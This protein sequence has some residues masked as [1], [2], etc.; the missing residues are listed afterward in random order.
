MIIIRIQHH[1]VPFLSHLYAADAAGTIQGGGAV[2]GKGG[3]GLLDTHLHIDAS[4][5]DSE[6]DGTGEAT[7]GIKVGGQCY[8]TAGVNHLTPAGIR[9]FQG[10]GGK[11]EQGG[12]H[13]FV[14]HGM[15]V[16]IGSV[17]QVVGGKFRSQSRTAQRHYFIGMELQRQSHITSGSQQ[18]SG[19]PDGEHALLAK[20]I[21]K[22]CGVSQATVSYV[23]NNRQNQ[24]ISEET[25]RKVLDAVEALHYYPNASAK[26][27]RTKN[28][29][30][31]GIVCAK[32]YS[33]QAFLN[34]FTGIS[35]YLS[36]IDYTITIFNEMDDIDSSPD[37]VKSYYSNVIDGLIFISNDDHAAFTK[38]ADENHIPYVVICMDGVFSKKT[39]FPHA[40]E[41]ALQECASFCLEKGIREV[42]YF[43]IS[44]DGLLVN[45]KYPLFESLL[46]RTAPNCH[47]EHVICP[48]KDRD[49]IHLQQFLAKYMENRSFDLAISQ[50]YD[51]G[52]LLQREI[53]K[54]GFSIP[55]RIRHIFLNE[56]NFYEMDYPSISGIDIPYDQMG[57]YAAKLLLAMIENRESEFTYQEFKCRLIQRETT[58]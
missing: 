7:A 28:C 18:A 33:R 6:R 45:N 52:L 27:M 17:Q 35:Q 39:P 54:T 55:Q 2:Q 56:V 49:L 13:A 14:R 42:R 43:S 11:R 24:K 37:Y 29:T 44:N 31:I 8:G 10:K 46:R 58:L 3:N 23:I 22:L 19:L 4:Q 53:L 36:Q 32:D 38:P 9:F 41:Y 50:N 47:L 51:I 57:E 26:S 21:A 40:F 12:N 48:I 5:C 16:G 30:S 15:D 1:K 25:R 34:A 20:D